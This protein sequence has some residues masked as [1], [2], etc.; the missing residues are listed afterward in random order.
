MTKKLI[1]H[2]LQKAKEK[3]PYYIPIHQMRSSDYP[4]R[5]TVLSII[6]KAIFK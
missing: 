1:K 6:L 4:K 5:R 2:K 3:P